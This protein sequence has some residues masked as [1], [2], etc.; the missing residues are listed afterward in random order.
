MHLFSRF[1]FALFVTSGTINFVPF[2]D[3]M[4]P[5]RMKTNLLSKAAHGRMETNSWVS[6]SCETCKWQ[7]D[8]PEKYIGAECVRL[9]EL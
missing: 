2:R 9:V 5:I 3:G 8:T 6:D 4:R 1:Q 7:L